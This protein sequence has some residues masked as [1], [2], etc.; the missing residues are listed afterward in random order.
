MDLNDNEIE[1]IK[2][3][4]IVKGKY[5]EFYYMQD[6]N[7]SVLRLSPDPLSYWICT[8]DGH[9]KSTIKEMCKKHPELTKLQVLKLLAK[10]TKEAS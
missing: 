5:S 10:S 1:V 6:E 4:E 9:D 8:S 2:S 7:R 3:L